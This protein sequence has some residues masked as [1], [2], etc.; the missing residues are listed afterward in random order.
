MSDPNQTRNDT[1]HLPDQV[2]DHDFDGIQEYDNKLPNWWL[3]ILYGSIVFSVGYWLVFHTF[4]VGKLPLD[5]YAREMQVAAEAELARAAAGGITDES[6]AL[7]A[8]MPDRVSEGEQLFVQ[9]CAACHQAN[10]SGL[11]GPNLTD[12]YW[13]HGGSPLDIH[14]VV[15]DGV[16]A[17]GMVAWGPQLGPKRVES[18][19]AYVITLRG[20]NVPGKAP[21]GDPYAPASPDEG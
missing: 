7:V 5:R 17:K 2:L 14:K 1:G 3:F 4:E 20:T 6:L 8:G 15:T 18:L 9:H 10:G 21:E 12:D 16:P 19:V 13:V 11:V